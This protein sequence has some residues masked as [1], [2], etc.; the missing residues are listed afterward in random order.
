MDNH[1][2]QQ[3]EPVCRFGPGGDFIFGWPSKPQAS[4]YLSNR[5]VKLLNSMNEIL[6]AL[7]GCG[8][9]LDSAPADVRTIPQQSVWRKEKLEYAY[10]NDGLDGQ[11]YASSVTIV[12]SD[13]SL[14]GEPM[15]FSDDRG[16]V[17]T[18]GNKPKHRIRTYRRTAK[19][20]PPFGLHSQGSLFEPD[21]K[22][23]RIA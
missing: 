4:V 20:G 18:V 6:N 14:S 2:N 12:K 13:S 9:D 7:V 21:C 23:A 5:F 11:A 10:G 22:S 1:I 3:I 15:L 8:F 19:K 17:F 16:V